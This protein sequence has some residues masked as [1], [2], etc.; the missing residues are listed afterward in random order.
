[1]PS[2]DKVSMGAIDHDKVTE[3]LKALPKKRKTEID[4]WLASTLQFLEMEVLCGNFM[5]QKV[6]LDYSVENMNHP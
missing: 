6:L 5:F 1:M 2:V 4:C 3:T